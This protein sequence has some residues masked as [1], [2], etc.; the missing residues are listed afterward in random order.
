[1]QGIFF[2]SEQTVVGLLHRCFLPQDHV[3][4]YSSSTAGLCTFAG[5]TTLFLFATPDLQGLRGQDPLLPG[6]PGLQQAGQEQIR[7]G[8]IGRSP[9][10]A[11]DQVRKAF[12]PL[13]KPFYTIFSSLLA[14]APASTAAR[15]PPRCLL[16]YPTRPCAASA[17]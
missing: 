16:S 4:T 12:T 1:M 10:G 14:A 7:R 13:M 9:R 5:L 2:N 15:F 6:L 11:E 8:D 3:M 17:R